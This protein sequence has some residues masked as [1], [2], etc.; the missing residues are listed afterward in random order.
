MEVA[1]RSLKLCFSFKKL[2]SLIHSSRSKSY[3]PWPVESTPIVS[4]A[5]KS[6]M[7]NRQEELKATYPWRKHLS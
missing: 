3:P 4:E 2:S 6:Y 1:A 5:V 7:W